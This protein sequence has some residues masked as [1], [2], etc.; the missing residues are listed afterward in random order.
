MR[1]NKTKFKETELGLIPEDWQ[2]LKLKDLVSKVIDNRGKTPPLSRF[3]HGMIEV[4]AIRDDS[5]SPDFS[6]VRKFVNDDT[7]KT[8]FRGHIEV[9]D[10]LIST[11]GTIGNTAMVL[12]KKG[13]IAQNVIALRSAP[14]LNSRFLYYWLSSPNQKHEL[15]NLNIGGVQPS[16]KVPHLLDMD[17]TVPPLEEQRKIAEVLEALDEKIELNRKM[18]KTL[19][20][21]AQAV[22]KKWFIDDEST[23]E[24]TLGDVIEIFDSKRVPLSSRGREDRAGQYPYYGATS[25]MGYVDDY[26]FDGTYLLLGEDGSVAKDDGKPYT[27]YVWGKIWVNNHAHVLQG[28]N[29]ISTEL[30]KI[31]FDF[32]DIQPYVTGAVQPKLNQENLKSIPIMLPA[33]ETINIINQ[34]IMPMFETIKNNLEQIETLS[35]IRDSL[36]PRLMSGKLRVR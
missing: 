31:F 2:V 22:F 25:I 1:Q 7:Y 28:K 6:V 12:E 11:V 21:L 34:D 5:M 14:K 20:S 29:G 19:E 15:R 26:I 8:W 36:L 9:G 24:G 32:L 10:I 18:N 27:Q 4:N 23:N 30:L 17:I 3:G 33:A 16:I 35:Q 13:V